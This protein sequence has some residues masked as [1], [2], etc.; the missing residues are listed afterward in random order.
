MYLLVACYDT[1]VLSRK[2]P[3]RIFKQI[4]TKVL[5]TPKDKR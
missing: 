2:L 3:Y 4:L 5:I 1:L